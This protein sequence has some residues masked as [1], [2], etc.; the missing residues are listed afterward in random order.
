MEKMSQ[1]SYWDIVIQTRTYKTSS[2]YKCL[3]G[4]KQHV[5]WKKVLYDNYAIPRVTFTFWM[6]LMDKLNTKDRLLKIGSVKNNKCVFCQ[7]DETIN[8]FFLPADSFNAF[9]EEFYCGYGYQ[10]FPKDWKH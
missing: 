9:G 10:I 4:D 5:S 2:M 8:H 7:Q 3:R 6:T 1:T